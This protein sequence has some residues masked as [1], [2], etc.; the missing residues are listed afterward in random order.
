[1]RHSDGRAEGARRHAVSLLILALALAAC[2]RP[3]PPGE[4]PKR[5]AALGR[6]H[7]VLI[8]VDTLRA[9]WTTPYG[10]PEDTAPELARWAARGVLFERVLAQSSWTKMSVASLMTSL[11]PR[12]HAIRKPG[13]GLGEGAFTLA[14]V[15]HDAGYAT[16]G[17]QTNGWLHQSFGFHQGFDRYVF[18][19]GRGARLPRSN[20]WPH[21]DRVYAEAERLIDAH[22]GA[23]PFFLY[24]HFMDVHEYAAPPEFRT[25]GTDLKGT[26]LASIRWVNDGLARV[27]DKLDDAGALDRT[28]VV[29]GSDH[30][31]T[32]GEDG[33]HGHAR[34]VLSQVL[35]VPL[36]VRF[37]FPVEAVRVGTQVRNLDIAPTI[38][39]LAGVPV[40]AS[41][42]GRSLLPLVT[43]ADGADPTSFAALGQPLFP[44]ASVQRSVNDGHWT[45]ARNVELD[46]AEFLF[47]R[48]V[49]PG[50]Q[51]NLIELE[52]AQAERMRARLDGHL[53]SGAAEGVLEQD[54][55]IDPAIAERLRAMGYLQ[56]P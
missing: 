22:D 13:D 12:S 26:Y 19:H 31:E 49:D 37:P 21:V 51:V 33:K 4:I 44:D 18:P 16:Y 38:L 40:P 55:R 45:Y 39:D 34:N 8:L 10:F 15:L 17:V 43:G 11:W 29:F 23:R 52:P 56:D 46:D 36:I 7:I 28:I 54:V 3:V 41:F 53:A 27:I 14:E 6:P 35:W 32:F 20:V 47:D 1:L 9:D 30:G 42:E 50:E 5:L 2:E 24:L 25:Y 48:S